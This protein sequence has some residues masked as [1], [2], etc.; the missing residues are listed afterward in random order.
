MI[1][2][3]SVVLNKTVVGSCSDVSTTCSVMRLQSQSELHLVS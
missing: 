3:V 2:S 1:V